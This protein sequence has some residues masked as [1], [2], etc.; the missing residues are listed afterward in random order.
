MSEIFERAVD[1]S[2]E[3]KDPKRKRERRLERERE[4]GTSGG[5]SRPDEI[6]AQPKIE[7]EEDKAK[8]RYI[9]SEVKERVYARARYQCQYRAADGTRCSS[10]TG[11]EIEHERPFAIY[12]S[13][14]ERYLRVLCR[15]HNRFE[16]ERVYGAEFI[17][18]KI[19][20]KKRQ[21]ISRGRARQSLE[22]TL[23]INRNGLL[24]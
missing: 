19:D 12:R 14:E 7:G 11:L 21:K 8:S 22:S 18:N 1:I 13:H 9:P 4:R 3:K 2:L 17:R 24:H 5:K 23:S 10:R 6:S 15:R 16:A 20:E